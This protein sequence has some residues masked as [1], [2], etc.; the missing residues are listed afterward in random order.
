MRHKL[1]GRKSGTRAP[2]RL[3]SAAEANAR[4][5][6]LF[7]PMPPAPSA[8]AGYFE[9]QARL[10]ERLLSGLHQPELVA[11]LGKLH[12]E[13]EAKAGLVEEFPRT[14]D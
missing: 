9:R 13:F 11:L 12:E 14:T 5:Y 1:L 8:D 3:R 2:R 10:C 7:V 4:Q 6:S